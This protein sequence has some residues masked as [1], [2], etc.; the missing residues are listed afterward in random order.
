MRTTIVPRVTPETSEFWDYCRQ[1]VLSVQR[2]S[3][4][5]R[6]RFP[7]QPMCP[8]CHSV[9]RS[10]EPVDA[11][12]TLYTYTVVTGPGA[13]WEGSLPGEHGYPFVV[14]IVELALGAGD[15]RMVTD[16]DTDWIER[17]EIGMPLKVVFERV[18]DDVHLP[19]FVPLDA[20]E[21]SDVGH[22]VPTVITDPNEGK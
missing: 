1:G 16:I 5:E 6:W 8:E 9:S 21:P 10:W 17:L 14:G 11:S 7:P 22:L 12:A 15:V 2:C 4:C 3:D 18:N 20:R 19:R 13:D